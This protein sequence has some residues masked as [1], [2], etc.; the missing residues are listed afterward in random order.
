TFVQKLAVFIATLCVLV[1]LHEYG[2]FIVARWNRVRVTD[3]AVGFGKTLFMWTSPR[4]G[5]N[6]RIN[7]WPLGGYCAMQGEDGKSLESEQQREF[8]AAD[9]AGED[10]NF[11]AKPAAG[12]L[13]IV[14]AG[15]VAN[16]ILTFAIFLFSA[17]AFGIPT[18]A[19][20]PTIG[21]LIPGTPAVHVGLRM[22]DEVVAINGV[23][24]VSGA[25]LI[26]KIHGS[27][28]VPL[29]LRYRRAGVE[30]EVIVKPIRSVQ[31]GKVV[32]II[33]FR[34]ISSLAH[35]GL[36]TAITTAGS[37]VASIFMLN[38]EGLGQLVANPVH[39]YSSA[40]SVIGMER[41]ASQVQDLGWAA[42]FSFA[43]AISMALGIF[44]L[45]PIPALD[46]GRA[47]FIVAELV[48]GRPVD[49]EKEAFV[50]LT[51]MALLMALMVFLAFHDISNIIAG[52]G[53][54]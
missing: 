17:I 53:V 28:G 13:A 9:P 38:I 51:G 5:T 45:L 24:V 32:G 23:P 31:D 36:G 4:S 20:A 2:H 46:G 14:L 25:Q 27:L 54:F 11:Q 52:K 43:A 35:V 49:P 44:N 16:F 1:V 21:P 15:P 22:G 3:F 42:Y 39:N 50:H 18:D 47:A 29:R 30:Q 40:M 10:G 26:N 34:P 12:R 37:E 33:G 48:R 6:Y 41:A 8:L 19:E 7:L